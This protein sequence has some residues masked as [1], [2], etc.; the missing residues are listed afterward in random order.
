VVGGASLEVDSYSDLPGRGDDEGLIADVI[1]RLMH[2]LGTFA[3][4]TDSDAEGRTGTVRKVSARLAETGG[5]FAL[6][7]LPGKTLVRIS[8]ATD[9]GRV[10]R[11]ES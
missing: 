1:R 4:T 8:Q 3:A 6:T 10:E 2:R 5:K 7:K 11:V 9:N